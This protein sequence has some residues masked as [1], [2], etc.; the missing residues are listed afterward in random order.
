MPIFFFLRLLVRIPPPPPNYGVGWFYIILLAPTENDGFEG[1]IRDYGGE[2]GFEGKLERS[3]VRRYAK[4]K[5][6]GLERSESLAKDLEWFKEQGYVIPEPSA[7]AVNY[8]EYLK[9]LLEKDP[10]AFICHFYNI[11]FAHSA[12]RSRKK[13]L[14]ECL[15]TRVVTS[16]LSQLLQNVREKLNKVAE[17]WIREEK[18]HCLEETDKSFK[19]S[20]DILRLI[21]L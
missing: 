18:N 9:E 1:E 14:I 7:L 12:S 13:G 6:M 16:E 3:Y 20:G 2:T 5:N 19:Y 10:Q 4:L 8:A 15:R 17:T 21:L 11:Y